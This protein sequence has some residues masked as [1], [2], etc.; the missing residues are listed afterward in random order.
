MLK[1]PYHVQIT[2]IYTRAGYEKHLQKYLID[3]QHY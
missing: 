1:L 2:P 3:Y